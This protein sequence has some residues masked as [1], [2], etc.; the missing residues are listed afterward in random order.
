MIKT[1]CTCKIAKE[2]SEFHSGARRCKPCAIIAA[3]ESYTKNKIKISLEAKNPTKKEYTNA[4]RRARYAKNSTNIL[5][6]NKAWKNNN[7]E[8]TS[9]SVSNWQKKN[10]KKCSANTK[11]WAQANKGIVNAR[12][13]MYQLAKLNRTPAWLTD[14]DRERIQ[15][16][17]KLAEILRKVTNQ[18]WHVDHIIPLQGKIVSGLHVPSNLQVVVAKENIAKSNKFEV[19]L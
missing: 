7:P 1:C 13:R 4:L 12:T 6:R 10:P 17:Y 18:Q 8:K 16:E 14:I 9:L 11:K 19:T 5:A 3:K 15:N 2:I